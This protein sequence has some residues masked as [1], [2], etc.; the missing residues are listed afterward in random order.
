MVMQVNLTTTS[1]GYAHKWVR[2]QQK[3]KT[4]NHNGQSP[5]YLIQPLY[6]VHLPLPRVYKKDI[7][8]HVYEAHWYSF[9]TFSELRSPFHMCL[10]EPV[11]SCKQ[12]RETLVLIQNVPIVN[13]LDLI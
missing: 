9:K 10:Q 7:Y 1:D 5:S 4:S 12:F 2:Q 3:A 6:I 8:M 13:R 11:G